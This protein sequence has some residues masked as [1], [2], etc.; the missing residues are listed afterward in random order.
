MNALTPDLTRGACA[1][2]PTGMCDFVSLGEFEDKSGKVG[3]VQ[4]MQCRHCKL[5]VTTPP[6][7]DV[8]FLYEGRESQDFQPGTAGLAHTI[9][10]RAFRNQANSL[11]RQLPERPQR[12]LDFGCGSGQFTRCLG[13]VAPEAE[14]IGSDFDAQPPAELAGKPY[15][16]ISDLDVEQ[17][18]FDLVMAMHVLEHDDDALGLLDRIA[19]MARPGGLVVLEVPNIDCLWTAMLGQN[20]DAWYLPFHRTHFSRPSL[21]RLVH[22]AGLEI[23]A[24]HDCCVPTMGRSLANTFGRQNSLPFLL[25]GVA[26]HPIQWIGEKLTG[27][28][29]ALRV[30]AR[31]PE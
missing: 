3:K 28:P 23:L 6:L 14:V 21:S 29:S 8:A 18:S 5:G 2:A 7:P 9:K 24:E 1:V 16:C 11:L 25:A 10:D 26:L 20:W 15:R 22:T 30:I 27:R 17:G 31:R 19:S 4:V 12:I 13:E